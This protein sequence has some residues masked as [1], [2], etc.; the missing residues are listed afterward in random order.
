MMNIIRFF[1]SYGNFH[2]IQ[3]NLAFS[4]GVFATLRCPVA[5]ISV[6]EGPE[7]GI[8]GWVRAPG[9]LSMK[10]SDHNCQDDAQDARC[11]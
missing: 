7:K 2:L 9:F 8:S 3:R 5:Y 4:I 10:L 11:S 1:L 6:Q